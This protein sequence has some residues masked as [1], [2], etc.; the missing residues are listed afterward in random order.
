MIESEA[1][2]STENK[3]TRFFEI[4]SPSGLIVRARISHIAM[5]M[6]EIPIF[7]VEHPKISEN[8]RIILGL[9]SENI[10][11]REPYYTLGVKPMEK[12][13][14]QQY[15][16]LEYLHTKLFGENTKYYLRIGIAGKYFGNEKDLLKALAPFKWTVPTTEQAKSSK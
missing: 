11:F 14:M 12:D 15:G 2:Y 16:Q 5:T 9:T 8:N 1:K 3:H 13:V 10:A 4:K 7:D 6:L